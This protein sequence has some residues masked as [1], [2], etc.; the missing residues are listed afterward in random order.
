MKKTL[1]AFCALTALVGGAMALSSGNSN[2][3]TAPT[4]TNTTN[5]VEPGIAMQRITA[6]NTR[7]QVRKAQSD[8]T[9]TD[10][11][12]V[13]RIDLWNDVE[14]IYDFSSGNAYT[15][16]PITLSFAGSDNAQYLYSGVDA[17][18][19]T[20]QWYADSSLPYTFSGTLT[21][22]E[23]ATV[24][25]TLIY[26]NNDSW[27]I[28]H[29]DLVY[30]TAE[31]NYTG[32]FCAQTTGL[33]DGAVLGVAFIVSESSS[34]ATITATDIEF[35]SEVSSIAAKPWSEETDLP[36]LGIN[37]NV[38]PD[39][40]FTLLCEDGVTTLGLVYDGNEV[41]VTG[42]NTTAESVTIPATAGI[43]GM[44]LPIVRIG[45]NGMFNW[46]GAQ[47][48]K[49]L[50]T[51]NVEN[52]GVT[53]DDS[54]LTD[55]YINATTSFAYPVYS[56]G[57]EIYLHIPYNLTRSNYT[58]LG[59]KRVLV[60]DEQPFYPETE[61][62]DYVIAGY[63]EGEFFGITLRNNLFHISEIY[64]QNDTITIPF[65]IP[66]ADGLYYLRAVGDEL[67]LGYGSL[68][69]NAPALKAIT[70]PE[71]VTSLEI[72]WSYNP[73][74]DLYL[75]GNVSS[76]YWNL[77]SGMTLYVADRGS[78]SKYEGDSS[79][80]NA[81]I[82]PYG[83]EFDWMVV[84][85]ARKGEFAQTYI[86]M[87]DADWSLGMYVKVTGTLNATDLNNIKN[88]TSLRKLDLSEAQFTSL[89]DAFLSNCSTL[90]EVIL[91][92][93]LTIIPQEAFY[94]CRKLAK[95]TAPG[96]ST[97]RQ[98]AFYYC[99]ALTKFDIS[100][101]S[102]IGNSAFYNCSAFNPT[103]FSETLTSIGQS[104]F[105]NT[106]ISAVAIPEGVKILNS[107]V[108][109]SC[110]R[111]TQVELPASI[112]TIDSRAFSDCTSLEEV[113]LQE[114][115]TTIGSQAFYNC[116][117]L[118]EL[119]L[120]STLTTINSNA[121]Y[122]CSSL[123]SV[124]CKAVVPPSAS[125]S[126]TSG[127]DMNHCTLYVAPFAIDSYREAAYWQDFYIMK[128]LDEP[129]KNIYIE[130]PMAFNLLSEDNAVLQENP[131]M[132]LTYNTNKY[133]VGELSA[134]G[135]GTLSAGVFTIYHSIYRRT[136]SSYD[137][138]PSLVNNAE[139]MRADSVLCSFELEKNRW[140]FISFQYDVEMADIK[141]LYNTDFVIREYNSER[142]ATGD[143]SVSNWDDVAANGVLKAGKGYIIQAANNSKDASGNT[144]NAIVDFP[145]RNTVTK[146]KLF[147]SNNVIVALDEH[148]AEF[149]HNRSWNMVGNPYPCYY[150]MHYLLDDFS[151]PIVIWR[152][153]SYQAYSPVD[154]D[155]VLRPNESFF[156]QRP[157]DAEQMVFGAEGRMHY[158][159]A[160]NLNVTPGA[161]APARAAAG[162]DR[163]VFNFNVAGCGSDDRTRIVMN[164]DASADYEISR[165]AA[166]FFADAPCG[167]EL[168]VDGDVRYDICERPA[169]DGKATLGARF[170][171]EGEYTISLA[172]R[173]IAGWTVTLTDTLTGD[174]AELT[175]EAYTFTAKAGEATGRFLLSFGSPDQSSIEEIAAT[176]GNSIVRIVTPAGVTVFEGRMADFNAPA[177][178]IYVIC[179]NGK[180]YKTVVK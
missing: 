165:D 5:R 80:N 120:P 146:N 62:S 122:N 20:F 135:D 28:W 36:G 51:G 155:V 8:S 95:V 176:E 68:C 85:V 77:N 89:P 173:N 32:N 164:P 76:T 107:S 3:L 7:A 27:Y 43:N 75:L 98:S 117:Q 31:N 153:T 71:S 140:H 130:R 97:V 73:I 118:H 152:G 78:Y 112:R 60:G 4:V 64:T 40:A 24:A 79:W 12:V 63:N 6:A 102:I 67:N 111:L 108:F 169:G 104:A 177:P 115:I 45:Y 138:R 26:N 48:M 44:H 161:K 94:Y 137:Y 41:C 162:V 34:S 158:S 88:L 57:L 129:V 96:V 18:I 141:G 33:P 151:T 175:T 166:K 105:Y 159:E 157:L 100:N 132:T 143:G 55:I 110:S 53:L 174:T 126:F 131:N 125:N 148:P 109:S 106:A 25:A 74:T 154:D 29:Q 149:A 84:D 50:Y 82:L 10:N 70:V 19:S 119:T 37:G 156:V 38:N 83:W 145:S 172:G 81:T 13:S 167:V 22:D 114:G 128:P 160:T 142:R 86:E 49:T 121:L 179:G 171:T 103:Q 180:A 124:K 9:S 61:L 21:S 99:Q 42:L 47:S 144:Y 66:Y 123:T 178:G 1:S 2:P 93:T 116:R 127:M 59:F 87:T 15:D 39:E 147:T 17:G 101:V 136:N 139:N 69:A 113:V 30:L 133:T 54:Q 23:P 65:A 134:E 92:E 90:E 16:R 163:S 91:P 46:N 58:Y 11:S 14:V 72:Y 170:A 150:D 56:N 35:Y 168:F 52:V